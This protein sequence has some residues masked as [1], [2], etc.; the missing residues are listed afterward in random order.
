MDVKNTYTQEGGLKIS[1]S[2]IEKVARLAAMEVE[3][4]RDISV[5]STG[6]KGFFARTNLPKAVEVNMYDGVA[7]ITV[8]V[9]VKYGCRL[10]AVC[11]EIQHAVKAGVQNMT[12]IT[13]S[14]VNVV[15]S[16]VEAVER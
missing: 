4:V 5:G 2:V 14:K 1:V 9:I 10:P 6:V 13:V 11:K 7:D 8:N 3:G 15:I 16:G 12:N